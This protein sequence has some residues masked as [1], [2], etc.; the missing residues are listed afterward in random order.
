MDRFEAIRTLLAAVDGGSLT[1]ASRQLGTPL[2]TVSRHVSELE[3]RLGTQLVIRTNRK[4]LL[5]DAGNAFVAAGRR[6][7]EQLDEA[8]RAA[9]GEYRAP[10]G[11][12]LVTAPIMFGKLHVTPVVLAFLTAYP[13]VNVRVVFFDHVVDLVENH[14]DVAVR[15]GQLP[16]SGL[17]A[18]RIGEI[19]WVICASP[20]YLSTHG[21]P[22]VPDD[23]AE[24]DC[25]AFEGLQMVRTWP[26]GRG[27]DAKT[28]AIKPRFAANTADAVLEAA[29]AGVGIARLTS[30][31][32]AGAIREG[33]LVSL[34]HGHNPEPLPVHLVHTGPPLVPLKMRAFLDFAGPRLKADLADIANI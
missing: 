22:V 4:L 31:Q 24:H 6:V 25:I 26:F 21:T 10:R 16:D 9:A 19:R 32:A 20:A 12:L 5:T 27:A 14:V 34:L 13:E 29:I 7:L 1:A 3:A 33:R 18:A 15:I 2:P 11:D 23:L 17:V 8:E 30:Y 28:V